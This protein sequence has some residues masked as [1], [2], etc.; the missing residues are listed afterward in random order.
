M[1]DLRNETRKPVSRRKADQA[2]QTEQNHG[3]AEAGR[4]SLAGISQEFAGWIST[5]PATTH[6]TGGQGPRL[7]QEDGDRLTGA[8]WS[9]VNALKA[10]RDKD[11]VRR[12]ATA[13][14]PVLFVKGLN[15]TGVC[16]RNGMTS[17][18]RD[19]LLRELDRRF[20]E[21]SA[22]GNAERA[23]YLNDLYGK[24]QKGLEFL[25]PKES[26]GQQALPARV[27][28]NADTS[29]GIA[30]MGETLQPVDTAPVAVAEP[31]PE[32]VQ[33][34]KKGQKPRFQKSRK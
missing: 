25:K 34:A 29:K 3:H 27:T 7:G 26:A 20:Q 2:R 32:P 16:P 24:I 13:R 14:T 31:A 19:F 8:L 17:D 28:V 12:R 33:L 6:Q 15:E 22:E 5:R 21:A 4:G 10:V 11:R 9:L 18:S 30:T 23:K 1:R